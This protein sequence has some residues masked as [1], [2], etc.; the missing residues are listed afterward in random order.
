MD[1][2]GVKITKRKC[3]SCGNYSIDREKAV[4]VR[5]AV[6]LIKAA[7][8]ADSEIL[9]LASSDEDFIPLLEYVRF[10]GKKLFLVALF[11]T[12]DR[13]KSLAWGLVPLGYLKIRRDRWEQPCIIY[14]SRQSLD[15]EFTAATSEF[16][17]LGAVR[18]R[19]M[20]VTKWNQKEVSFLRRFFWFADGAVPDATDYDIA[21]RLNDG[22][23]RLSSPVVLG[24]WPTQ[25][26][27]IEEFRRAVVDA[28][29]E[30][31]GFSARLQEWRSS[32]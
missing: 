25:A 22:E 18:L 24:S 17:R 28:I 30:H 20:A 29:N 32:R 27:T 1:E 3:E 31:K 21:K 14:D 9:V 7:T 6:D 2:R 13:M 8:T 23:L 5:L 4:D 11:N 15:E 10:I 16:G 26:R 19:D 12:T